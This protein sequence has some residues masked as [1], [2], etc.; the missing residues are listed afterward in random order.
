M[1]MQLLL[2][3]D[4]VSRV[5]FDDDK[6]YLMKKCYPKAEVTGSKKKKK[7]DVEKWRSTRT[8]YSY[9]I[10]YFMQK[11]IYLS[12]SCY[13][14]ATENCWRLSS[15]LY[16]LTSAVD[17]ILNSPYECWTFF[18]YENISCKFTDLVPKK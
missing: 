7:N 4:T 15:I 14:K 18:L 17:L 10:L 11:Y 12:S 13:D 9:I 8:E 3:N 6:V 16:I 2:A 5:L 1:C